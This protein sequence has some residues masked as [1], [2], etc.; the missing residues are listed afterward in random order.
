V[1]AV[2]A[3]ASGFKQSGSPLNGPRVNVDVLKSIRIA[4]LYSGFALP[5]CEKTPKFDPHLAAADD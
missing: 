5:A 4:A 2:F 3:N 1:L